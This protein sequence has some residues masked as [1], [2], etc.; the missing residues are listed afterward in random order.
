MK[1]KNQLMPSLDLN[2]FLGFTCQEKVL[3]LPRTNIK[4]KSTKMQ[5]SNV[6]ILKHIKLHTQKPEIWPKVS[7]F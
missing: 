7:Q 4:F 6:R 1:Y 2:P 3:H 5:K